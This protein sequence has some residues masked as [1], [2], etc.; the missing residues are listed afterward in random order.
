MKDT[1]PDKQYSMHNA[2]RQ[3]KIEHKR[4]SLQGFSIS[5]LATYFQV[6]EL[7]V[8]VDM[9]E[10]PMSA[11]SLNHVLLTHSHGDHS[12]CLM[13]HNSLRRMMQNPV[14]A[15]YY[16]PEPVYD[17]AIDLV[18][19]ETLFEGVSEERFD[20]PRLEC[21]KAGER[22]DLEYRKDL[23]VYPFNVKHSIA[24]FGYTF[25]NKKKKLK[26]EYAQHSREEII[27]LKKSGV[28]ITDDVREPVIS[29]LGDCLGE[30]L[31]EERHVWN[32]PTVVCECTFLDEDEFSMAR[33]KGHTHINHL[34]QVLNK[35]GSSMACENI[36]LTHFSMKYSKK[37]VL[38][39]VNRIIP[40]EFKEK[41]KVFL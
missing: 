1:E 32:S 5:G 7:D 22:F 6:P 15:V 31:W 13:R 37:H 28:E 23:E 33:K 8:C 35:I 25:F 16:I 19:A 3:V 24:A 18:K 14:Q 29:F 27:S 26:K 41:V 38:E 30:S 4:W 12:R 39:A 40:A 17:L 34:V 9:G 10:C 21:V 2:L 20:L 11:L 36:I